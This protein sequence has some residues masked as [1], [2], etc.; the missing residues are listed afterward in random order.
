MAYGLLLFCLVRARVLTCW[1]PL[2][3]HVHGREQH[4][5]LEPAETHDATRVVPPNERSPSDERCYTADRRRCLTASARP[6]IAKS[7]SLKPP[8]SWLTLAGRVTSLM[9]ARSERGP[10]GVCPPHGLES[11]CSANGGDIMRRL[12]IVYCAFI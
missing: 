3:P 6:A 4:E 12:L 1:S 8:S 5:R 7:S 11:P 10:S 9:A 2:R